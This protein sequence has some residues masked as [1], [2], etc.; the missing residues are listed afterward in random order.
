MPPRPLPPPAAV[1]RIRL[2]PAVMLAVSLGGCV[3]VPQTQHVFDPACGVATKQITLEV[4]VLPG[5]HR[6]SGDGCVALMV[7]AG[8]V[9]VASAVISGSVAVI[10]NV[11]YWA[12]RQAG[13]PR[14]PGTPLPA[15]R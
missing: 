8:V 10:G 4:A 15:P 6:C 9:T 7:T 2:L 11:L 3:V 5:F 1:R 12:E 13:C 14:P